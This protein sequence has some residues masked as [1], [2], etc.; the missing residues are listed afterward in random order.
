MYNSVHD[1]TTRLVS[2]Y[3]CIIYHIPFLNKSKQTLR[4]QCT[5]QLT[6]SDL[7]FQTT[8]IW[9]YRFHFGQAWYCK[10]K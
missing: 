5:N 6:L 4:Y 2:T 7:T 1:D 10:I 8:Q 9:E 3:L